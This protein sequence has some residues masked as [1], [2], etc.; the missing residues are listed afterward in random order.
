MWEGKKMNKSENG[1]NEMDGGGAV[2]LE[3]HC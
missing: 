3:V 1:G 2:I